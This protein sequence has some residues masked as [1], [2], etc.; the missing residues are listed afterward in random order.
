[1]TYT[2]RI[3]R[4]IE[5]LIVSSLSRA[6]KAIQADGKTASINSQTSEACEK[7]AS[8]RLIATLIIEKKDIP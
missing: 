8:R 2:K 6:N 7:F 3:A 4:D 5:T 1:M